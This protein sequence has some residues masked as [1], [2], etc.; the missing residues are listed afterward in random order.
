MRLGSAR[1][2]AAAAAA[3]DTAFAPRPPSPQRL[4]DDGRGFK[5]FWRGLEPARQRQLATD[6]APLVLKARRGGAGGGAGAACLLLPACCRPPRAAA[7]LAPRCA[8][9]DSAAA[10]TRPVSAAV[11][12]VVKRF[13]NEKEVTSTLV[14]D[15]L[16]CGA[17]L[18]EEAGRCWLEGQA[19]AA[20]SASGDASVAPPPALPGGEAP[21]GVLVDA[22]RGAFFFAGDA[23]AVLERAAAATIPPFQSDKAAGELPLRTAQEA[24][25]HSRDVVE[26]DEGRLADLGRRC[27]E[28]FAAAHIAATHM[29]ARGPGRGRPALHALLLLLG[30]AAAV[31]RRVLRPPLAA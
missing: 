10:N 27:V 4:L 14:M 30:A 24:D 12:G 18:L 2:R 7:L 20:T 11:Q 9:R 15:A 31:S 25:D 1:A 6:S 8:H 26:R 13:F 23:V 17:K 22:R 19:A 16:Y 5:D 29:E 21:A 3:A 28:M